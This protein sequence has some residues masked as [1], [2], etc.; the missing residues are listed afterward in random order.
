M[1]PKNKTRLLSGTLGAVIAIAGFV[2]QNHSLDREKEVQIAVWSLVVLTAAVIMNR[3]HYRSAWF[4]QG[5][6]I[7]SVLHVSII[8][9]VRDSLPFSSFAVVFLVGLAEAIV[10]QI[11]FQLLSGAR[12]RRTF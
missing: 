6:A 2:L 11:I 9:M 1:Q 8:Y 3:E 7:G 10:W 12:L 5:L 4:W